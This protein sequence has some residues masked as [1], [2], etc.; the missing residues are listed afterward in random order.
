MASAI[1]K[2]TGLDCVGMQLREGRPGSSISP[3]SLLQVL[4]LR[5]H[6]EFLP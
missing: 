6:L 1:P 5:S 4:S 2:H 3:W